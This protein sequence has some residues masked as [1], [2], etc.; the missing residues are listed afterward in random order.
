MVSVSCKV[1]TKLRE[2][3]TRLEQQ[4][5]E[6]QVTRLRPEELAHLTQMK[7]N[8]EIHK[9]REHLEKLSRKCKIM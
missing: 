2:T 3:T 6:E 5:V 4:L 7:S 9:L 8:D 1:K